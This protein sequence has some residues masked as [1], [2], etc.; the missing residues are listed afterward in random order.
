MYKVTIFS[1]ISKTSTDKISCSCQKL[2][3]SQTKSTLLK[4]KSKQAMMTD[5]D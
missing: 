5:S 4:S 3:K 1:L 2:N